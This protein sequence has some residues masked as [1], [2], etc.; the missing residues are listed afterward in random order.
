MPFEIGV[1]PKLDH[2]TLPALAALQGVGVYA[3]SIGTDII[4]VLLATFLLKMKGRSMESAQGAFRSLES[5][6]LFHPDTMPFSKCQC[7][8]YKASTMQLC[9]LSIRDSK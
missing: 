9:S 4:E 7:L 3:A 2:C 5:P 8:L 1:D 6:V